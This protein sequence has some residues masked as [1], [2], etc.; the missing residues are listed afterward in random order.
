MESNEKNPQIQKYSFNGR[1]DYSNQSWTDDNPK[2]F[3]DSFHF[4]S[5]LTFTNAQIITLGR[6]GTML[7]EKIL[8]KKYTTVYRH[9]LIKEIQDL[10][11]IKDQH[12]NDLENLVLQRYKKNSKDIF[13]LF[14]ENWWEWL[15]SELIARHVGYH[16][17]DTFDY[18]KVSTIKFSPIELRKELFGATARIKWLFNTVCN[19]RISNPE[20]PLTIVTYEQILDRYQGKV[21]HKQ[22]D[23]KKNKRSFF[24]DVGMI[25]KNAENFIPVWERI[26][27]NG[28]QTLKQTRVN[29]GYNY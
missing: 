19:F 3:S 11:M 20:K 22:I 16:H 7:F 2:I 5:H 13:F 29:E 21:D 28:I 14:R 26:R 8:E 27:H 25:K 24:N 18:T 1:K 10:T 6:S 23:Y 4:N 15:L 17:E 12:D 9:A